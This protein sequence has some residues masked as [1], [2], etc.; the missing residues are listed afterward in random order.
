MDEQKTTYEFGPFHLDPAKHLLLRDGQPI[1]LTPKAFETLRML[2]ENS[3]QVVGKDE[4]MQAIWPD[5]S[6]EEGSLT[7]NIYLLRKTLGESPNDHRYIVTV[8]GRGYRFVA[9][10][11]EVP[12]ESTD[13]ED[14]SAFHKAVSSAEKQPVQTGDGGPHPILRAEYLTSEIKHHKRG[15]VF[16]LATSVLAVVG[17]TFGLYKFAGQHQSTTKLIAPFQTMKITRLTGN[18]K[19]IKAAI[20]P[21]GKYVVYAIDDSEQESLWVRQV[22]TNS[23]VQIVPPFKGGYFGVTFSPD[24]NYVYYTINENSSHLGVLYQAPVLGGVPR[25]LLLNI[26][27]PPTFSPD[28]KRFAFMRWSINPAEKSLM[29][30]N[31]DGTEEQKLAVLKLPDYFSTMGPAWSPDGK[32]IACVAIRFNDGFHSDLVGVRVAD[33]KEQLVKRFFDVGGRVQWLSDGSGLVVPAMEQAS[34]PH[35]I[36]QVSYPGGEARRVTNDLNDYGGISLTA[37]SSAL[38][39]LQSSRLSHIWVAPNGDANHATQITSGQDEG[40][41][42]LSWMP[43]GKIAYGSMASGNSDIWMMDADG[44]NQQQ[45][46]VNESIDEEPSLTP[47]G[48]SVV[49]VSNRTNGFGIWRMDTDGGNPKQLTISNIKYAGA[50]QCSPDMQWVVFV[51]WRSGLPTLWK[52]PIGGGDAVQLTDK[53]SLMPAISP[54]GKLIACFYGDQQNSQKGIAIIPFEGGQPT[55]LFNIPSAIEFNENGTSIRWMPD[56]HAVTYINTR[57]DI[58]NIW[59]QPLDGSPPRRLTDFRAEEIFNF[60]WSPDG[61]QLAYAQGTQTTDVV[62]ISNFK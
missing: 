46:T 44:R 12:D 32:I 16:V 11:R 4:M 30:A 41:S 3:Q 8:P 19:A 20:S 25:K 13:L 34:E 48:R 60:A 29:V 37:D 38:V 14:H 49:F 55:K 21:D 5:T 18:G 39:T 40:Y 24:S 62:L 36:W 31:A 51:S 59:R 52:V 28:G 42:G 47:D 27:G 22:A 57:N 50:P 15:A 1:P 58:S 53:F 35:Q 10:V 6:V 56:G 54:D 2:V 43:D 23:T 17:I 9:S 61:K 45:L 33:G 26:N 7:R